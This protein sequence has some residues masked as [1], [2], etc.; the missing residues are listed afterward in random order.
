MR[1][2]YLHRDTDKMVREMCFWRKAR[3]GFWMPKGCGA[4]MHAGYYACNRRSATH[5]S[6]AFRSICRDATSFRQ[7][8]SSYRRFDYMNECLAELL[9]D[10]YSHFIMFLPH[11]LL[12]C[13]RLRDYRKTKRLSFNAIVFNPKHCASLLKIG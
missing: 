13:N 4:I 10:G 8:P 2:R 1:L 9:E 5:I 12:V 3:D 6:H 7:P 11:F